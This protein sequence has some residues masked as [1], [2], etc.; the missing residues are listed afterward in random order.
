MAATVI[1]PNRHSK[2]LVITNSCA[3]IVGCLRRLLN[4][5]AGEEETKVRNRQMVRKKAKNPF[6][7]GCEWEEATFPDGRPNLPRAGERCMFEMKKFGMNGR[8]IAEGFKMF[9]YRCMREVI[10]FPLYKAKVHVMFVARW[11][12]VNDENT[13]NPFPVNWNGSRRSEFECYEE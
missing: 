12:R 2:K 10:Y 5:R 8:E 6:E 9:G 3:V 7:E 1:A 13:G 11:K 4:H